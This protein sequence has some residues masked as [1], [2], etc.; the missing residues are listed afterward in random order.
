MAMELKQSLKL[1]QQLVMTPQLQ[2]A[3]KLLQLSRMELL[4]QVREEMEQNPLLEQPEEG[5]PGEVSEKEPGEASLEADNTE[6]ARDVDLPSATPENAQEF[7]ADGEGPPEIDW[8]SYLNSYQFNEPTTASNKGNVATDDLPSFEANMVKK[9]DLVDHLQEQ[10][11]TL[12]LNEAERRVGVLILGNLDDD[13][14][15]KLQDVEGDPLI[16]LAN[17]A[18]VPMHVAERTLRRI[19]NLEPRGCGAR[20]LQ[21]C[22]LIQLQAMKDPNA[23]LLGLIIKRH[24]KYLESKNLPAIAKDLKVTLDEVVAAAKLLPKLDP[25][26][27]R[28]FSGDDAQ[29]ITP[30]VFVYK[31]GDDDYTVVLNDDGLSKL[32]ISGMYRNALKT[33][34]VSPGQTK[35]FIQDKLRSAMWLIRSIHQRQ[36]TIYKVTESIVKF[37]RDFL[38]KGIAHLKPLILRDVAEDIG[39]HESTVSRVTTSKYV[40]T[41]QGIFELKYFF[42]SSIARVSGEDTASEAVKHHIKQLVSQ[43]DPR[44]PYSDQKI[45]E[46]LRSQGTEIARR[47]VAKY[48]E[49][50]GI[51][52]SSKRKKYF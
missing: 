14:Y 2:Q 8:E 7:K 20:D 31:L 3:I 9:E 36:R 6:I 32:R 10:L 42:N 1:A 17:E 35:E 15:L 41:P 13:G 27:G 12:R 30:D 37:Q 25:R 33:G 38:D 40:H 24:M 46:L 18:D 52:P 34:A 16:R 44:N 45:V 11:G 39:M 21:E 19:Q 48:R 29:Y 47:T 23:A 28:N 26:P 5:M 49:V 51:L 43:E 4:D 50:L 22:L